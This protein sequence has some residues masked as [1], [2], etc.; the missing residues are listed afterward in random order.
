VEP[1]EGLDTMRGNRGKAMP[2]RNL[3][4]GPGKLCQAFG[5]DMALNG[6]NLRGRTLWIDD[7]GAAPSRI[8]SRLTDESHVAPPCMIW[9]R[10]T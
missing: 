4:S 2:D 6:V 10:N 3:T 9:L 5:I 1:L 7:R 8:W